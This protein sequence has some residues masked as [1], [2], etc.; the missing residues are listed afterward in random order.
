MAPCCFPFSQERS[1]CPINWEHFEDIQVMGWHSY[2]P[3]TAGSLVPEV[4]YPSSTSA[5][6]VGAMGRRGRAQGSALGQ[7]PNLPTPRL[8]GAALQVS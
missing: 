2:N 4:P 6:P 3:P 5:P 7:P 1:F 8:S